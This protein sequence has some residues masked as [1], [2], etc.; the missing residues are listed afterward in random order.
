MTQPPKKGEAVY[1]LL[2]LLATAVSVLAGALAWQD[3]VHRE[4]LAKK[5]AINIEL[6]EARTKD[7]AAFRK[8]IGDLYREVRD[9]REEIYRTAIRQG[10]TIKRPK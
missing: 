10:K 3:R 8:E 6:Q 4:E 9:F 1:W 2:G 7:Q 5:D